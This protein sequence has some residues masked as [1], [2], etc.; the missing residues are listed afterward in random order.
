M[1]LERYCFRSFPDG[2]FSV[3][4]MFGQVQQCIL[5]VRRTVYTVA[6]LCLCVLLFENSVF[7]WLM[8]LMPP[9]LCS[10]NHSSTNRF[11]LLTFFCLCFTTTDCS[12]QKNDH[13]LSPHSLSLSL[14]PSTLSLPALSPTLMFPLF[15]SLS[16]S[17]SP[18][19]PSFHL[20]ISLF[21]QICWHW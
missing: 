15:L 5:L 2:G 3:V 10:C 4:E 7:K 9:S 14:P 18:L 11:D 1:P 12:G 13:C 20:S 17:L 8:W 21:S 19:C 6:N 16:H